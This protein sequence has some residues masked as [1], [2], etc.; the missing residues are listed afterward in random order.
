MVQTLFFLRFR[1]QLRR[2]RPE[3]VAELEDSF[4]RAV[5]AAGGCLVEGRRILSASLDDGRIGFW[6]DMVIFLE[7]LLD[8]LE[9]A[10]PEL[11]GYA[12]VLGGDIPGEESDRLCRE[13]SKGSVRRYTGVWCARGFQKAL[14]PFALFENSGGD[15]GE[16]KSIGI[17]RSAGEGFFPYREKIERA[18]GGNKNTLLLGPEF[19]GKRDGVYHYCASLPG[20]TPPLIIRFG[21]GGRGLACFVD[22]LSPVVRNFLG[23]AA[24]R[25]PLAFSKTLEEL[26]SRKEVLF[27]ERLREE[28]SPPAIEECR[29]FLR[30]LLS[31]Y[32][33]AIGSARAVLILENLPEGNGNAAALFRDVW[34][35][36]ENQDGFLI[37]GICCVRA[38]DSPKFAGER[39]KD[40]QAVFPRILK[41]TSEDFPARDRPEMPLSLWETAYS[42]SLLGR[43]F[44]AWFF[45]RLFEEEGLN[46]RL[47]AKVLE[48]L[49]RWGIIDSAED[50][51]PRI[52]NFTSRAEKIL[53]E[54]KEKIQVMVRN[55]LLAWANSGRLSPCFR[56]LR[57]L[58]DLGGRVE[59]TLVLRS[60]RGDVFNGT[61][62]DIEEAIAG[63]SFSPLTGTENAPALGWIYRTLRALVGGD[64]AEIRRVF[65]SPVPKTADLFPG[66]GAQI[67]ANLAIF[68][69]GRR[70]AGVAAETVKEA[71]FL[72]QSSQDGAVPAYRLFSLVNLS[73]GRLDDA[74]EY[75][76]F[77]MEQ[78]EKAEEFEELVKAA[79]YA[80]GI[81]FL[82]G[83][84]SK[85][86]RLALKA[87]NTAQ[88][89]GRLEWSDRARFLRGRFR[90]EAGA[91]GEALE[92]FGALAENAAGTKEEIAAAWAYRAGVYLKASGYAGSV[93]KPGRSGSDALLF[94]AEAA[95]LAGDY[96]EAVSLAE[97][98][99]EIPETAGDFL[100][101][102]F[103]NWQ[104]GF[105]Q[106]ENILV[107]PRIFRSRLALVYL[108]LA[109]SRLPYGDAGNGLL[110]PMWR[111]TR[112][113][114][115]N[116]GDP[117]DA[118]CY[119]GYYCL[120]Q[121]AGAAQVDMG[122]AVSMAFKRLQRRAS[123]IDDPGTRQD[124]V[125]LN[126]WNSALSLVAKE[127][128]LI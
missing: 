86:E 34:N 35:S 123:R 82:Y 116:D 10:G 113:E 71:M 7:A 43:Y 56:L 41:F 124:Y 84:L 90:F 100:F 1:S 13:L 117:Y 29:R 61:C 74:I 17:S 39:F 22:A 23:A 115:L 98:L 73:R 47:P 77:A 58:S 65:D 57:I 31:A 60:F 19:M 88:A 68:N 91:Y 30:L 118:F 14:E 85:A 120:L 102:E 122:T 64:E 125:S 48:I 105:A 97:A 78:S 109:R 16:L 2:I 8:C 104:S 111:L 20:D 101:T 25:N 93:P 126:R 92:I 40:W 26:D 45:P 121:G 49:F 6:L 107:P 27:K 103:P 81:Q 32:R 108:A 52:Q 59:D 112:E 128:K 63:G 3:T 21:P 75:I 24:F 99:L 119:Y 70:D 50:P 54:R 83:N 4:T 53:G 55:R 46:P 114:L 67:Q 66:F 95:F 42:L 18:L 33:T 89:A 94:A 127:Y 15:Y 36:L 96:R 110:D 72:N 12:L 5:S 62:G 37:F 76:N 80:A 106:C 69:L 44:P 9:K 51:R 28:F 38:G 11:S 87:E 79:Y